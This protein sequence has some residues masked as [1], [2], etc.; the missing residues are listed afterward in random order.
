MLS[1][2]QGAETVQTVSAPILLFFAA[3]ATKAARGR[4]SR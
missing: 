4:P 3:L 1:I 2:K